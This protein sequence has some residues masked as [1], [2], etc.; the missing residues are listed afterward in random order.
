[1]AGAPV[2]GATNAS[3]GE[4]NVR[5]RVPAIEDWRT[6]AVQ[7]AIFQSLASM[8]LPA[9]TIHSIV[10]YSGRALKD[11]KNTRIRTYGPIGVSDIL[12]CPRRKG[13][14]PAQLGLAAVPFLPF[15]FDKPVEDAVEWSFHKAFET[16]GG[17]DAI[18]KSPSTGREHLLA[19]SSNKI[20]E[21]EL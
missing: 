13:T 4:G 14:N 20:K 2:R 18:G 19:A 21:K 6:V 17:P 15:I 10:R 5:G 8:G 9:F 3:I 1:M 16:I 7:R 11:A 12:W